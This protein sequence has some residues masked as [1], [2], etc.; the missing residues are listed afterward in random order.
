MLPPPY[1]FPYSQTDVEAFYIEAARQI[2]GPLFIYN[3]PTFTTPVET[4]IIL[5]LV[6]SV[7]NI[8]GVKDSSGSLDTLEALTKRSELSVC[9]MVGHDG[10]LCRA[11]RMNSCDGAISGVAGVLPELIVPLFECHQDG[12]ASRFNFFREKL[13][14][15]LIQ[16]DT[17][18]APWGLKVIAQYRGFFKAQFPLPLSEERVQQIRSF[19]RWFDKWWQSLNQ[20]LL[21]D[22]L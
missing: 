17:F 10:V 5:R 16:L 12:D 6:E 11:L 2:A 15:L 19:E 1:F 8:V 18:P 22:A 7:P 13:D 20:G 21:A 14:E 9:R 4:D 3:L